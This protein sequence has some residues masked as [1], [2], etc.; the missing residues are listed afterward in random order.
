MKFKTRYFLFI[1]LF[2]VASC[3]VN[4]INTKST[5]KIFT[6]LGKIKGTWKSEGLYQLTEKW[7]ETAKGS[8]RGISKL[9]MQGL[10]LYKDTF[11]IIKQGEKIYLDAKIETQK[12]VYK[13][14]P[15]ALKRV[16]G[17]LYEFEAEKD[18]LYPKKITYKFQENEQLQITIKGIQEK[19]VT[20][21]YLLKRQD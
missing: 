21:K 1:L 19:K 3:K 16:K 5:N 17:Q 2:L 8:Y 9:K 14:L 15:M 12:D 7:E 4:E 11:Y 20:D 18:V 6:E 13:R 10:G